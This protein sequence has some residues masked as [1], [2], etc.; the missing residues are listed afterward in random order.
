MRRRVLVVLGLTAFA[1]GGT[2]IAQGGPDP[3][4][5]PEPKVRTGDVL[6]LARASGCDRNERVRVR[7]TPPAGAVFGWFAVDVRGREMVRMTG[8]ARAASATVALPRGRSTIRV[9]GE[10]LGGQRVVSD[11]VYRTCDDPPARPAPPPLAAPEQPVQV[12]GGED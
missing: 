4:E 7:F 11:R 2:A 9:Q 12:G 5:L 1:A 3:Y 6:Q 10:T 8:V